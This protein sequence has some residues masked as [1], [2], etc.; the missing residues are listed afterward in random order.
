MTT[1]DRPT[2]DLLDPASFAGGHPH[3][4]Y[5][6]LRENDPVYHHREPDGPGF[7]AVTRHAD[8]REVGRHPAIFSSSPTIMIS[9]EGALDLGDHQMMLMMDPPRHGAFRRLMIPDFVPKAVAGIRDRVHDLAGQIIDAVCE[10]GECDLVEDVA[11]EMP[12]F[13]VAELLG[14]PL[15]DGRELYKLTETIH[16]APES[17]PEGAGTAAVMQMFAYA[18]E[19]FQDRTANPKED[20]SSRLVHSQVEGRAFDE[21]DFGLMFVLLVDAG[22]DT[23]RNLVAG[24]MD[25]L[26]QHPDELALL[27]D[28]LDGRMPAAMEELLRWVSPVTYMRRTATT[29]AEVGGQQVKAG[30]KVVLYYGSANRDDAVFA[31][32]YRLDLTRTPNDHVAF[33]GGGPHFCLGAHLARIEVDALL[34]ELLTRLPDVAPSGETEWLASTFISGPKHLP[35]RFTSTA[36]RS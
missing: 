31:D 10:R 27:Q 29:D 20:L 35:V 34:R 8:V 33:G 9:D 36:R 2:I 28:G 17:L 18:N 5:R 32:P 16:A 14:L 1:I 25:A 23:T 11:G 26:F 4:Q 6:W 19:V 7:W 22:G 30:D 3:D 21:I 13:V 15:D 24:G 12:S